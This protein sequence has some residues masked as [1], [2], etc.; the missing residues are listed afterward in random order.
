MVKEKVI[1]TEVSKFGDHSLVRGDLSSK[2]RKLFIVGNGVIENGDIPLKNALKTLREHHQHRF[3][4]ELLGPIPSLSC[5]SAIGRDLFDHLIL[6]GKGKLLKPLPEEH[7]I[8]KLFAY[9]IESRRVLGKSYSTSKDRLRIKDSCWKVLE[10]LGICDDDS[11]CITTNW[12]NSLWESSQIKCVAH[13][14][15]RCSAPDSMILPTETISERVLRGVQIQEVQEK[16]LS[17]FPEDEDLLNEIVRFYSIP[18]DSIHVKMCAVETQF[19][20]RL[21]SVEEVVIIG[22]RFND[23]DHELMSSISLSSSS[24]CKIVLVNTRSNKEEKIKKVAGLF[25]RKPSDIVYWE[26]G[27]S[28]LQTLC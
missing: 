9:S 13:L 7:L 28:G 4:W 14:H 6:V 23:Y 25:S 2:K 12:D 21:S 22:V 26:M 10:E 15:G 20:E 5:I 17:L 27:Y 18:D 19:R 16:L 3:N 1:G 24:S 8:L 11:A